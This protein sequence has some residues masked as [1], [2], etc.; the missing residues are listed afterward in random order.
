MTKIPAWRRYLTFWRTP[1]AQDVDDE[2]RFHTSMRVKEYVARGMSED[3]ARRAVAM[4]LGDMTAAQSE[5][6]ELS[7]ARERNR[8]NA[9]FL[10]ALRSDVRYA[11]R[12]LRARP[13]FAAAIILT[14]GLG[15]GANA[16]VFSVVDRLLFRTAPMLRDAARTHRVYL[17]Y[18]NPNLEGNFIL[19]GVPYARIAELSHASKSLVRTAAFKSD[20]FTIG[21]PEEGRDRQIAGVTASF[22]D[23]FDAPPALGRYFNTQEDAPPNG[24][25]VVVLSYGLW[26]TE[27]GGR[28]DALGAKLRIGE[29]VYTVIGV[30]PRWFAGMTP[31]TPPAAFIPFSSYAASFTYPDRDGL[32]WWTSYDVGAQANMLVTR[33]PGVS[34]AQ[35]RDE[36]TRLT[37]QRW[38]DGISQGPPDLQPTAVVASTLAERG[39]EQTSASK[40]AGLVGAMALVVLLIAGA[41][42]A[43]LLLARALRRRREVAVRLAL[44]VSRSRLVSQFLT[45]TLVLAVFGGLAG[46]VAAR[47]GGPALRAAFLTP[48]ADNTVVTDARTLMFVGVI[49]VIAG[50]LTGLAPAWHAGRLDVTRHLRIGVREGTLQRSRARAALLVVQGRIV[51]S[52]ARGGGSVRAKSEQRPQSAARLRRG[53]AAGRRSQHARH[54]ARQRAHRRPLESTGRVGTPGSWCRT[55]CGRASNALSMLRPGRSG[56]PSGRHGLDPLHQAAGN[57]LECR[58]P[59]VFRDDAHADRAR[60]SDRFERRPRCATSG[61]RQQPPGRDAVA[62]SRRDRPMPDAAHSRARRPPTRRE[63][64]EVVA[65]R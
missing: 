22:F 43:N 48:S 18:P 47:W 34:V 19:D 6:V 23:F 58:F 59:G 8:R 60:A 41:N 16:A 36:L 57:P 40:V 61:G 65:A 45:E 20:R 55:R 30:A 51:G 7:E 24:E 31:D 21:E 38:G 3:E 17:S 53:A 35:V 44:G 64:T 37:R 39:P 32:R 5:C 49:V 50:V 9:A 63:R 52:T 14:L 33:K 13:G 1:I 11:L 62:G 42:V 54:S 46:L 12:G 27:Y 2:L 28:A 29:R 56:G 26:Q 25:T 10:D 15:I 4:R